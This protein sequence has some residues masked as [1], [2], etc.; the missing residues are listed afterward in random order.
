MISKYINYVNK[1]DPH[2]KRGHTKQIAGV[3]TV[4]V[5]VAWL[6]TFGMHTSSINNASNAG[7]IADAGEVSTADNFVASSQSAAVH[8]AQPPV[9]TGIQ[10][11]TSSVLGAET[12]VANISAGDQDDNIDAQY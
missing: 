8:L 6:A 9:E 2:Q 12:D 7:T 10:I 3:A 1:K 5:A 11:S 4:L